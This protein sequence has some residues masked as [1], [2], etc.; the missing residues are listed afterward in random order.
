MK[1]GKNN[2]DNNSLPFLIAEV[3]QNHEG[4]LSLAHAYID[5]VA[6][7]GFD[8]IKFQTHIASAESTLNEKF[9]KPISNQFKSRYDYWKKMEFSESQWI[10]LSKHA[11][12]KNLVFLSS[13]FSMQAFNLLK[14]IG[15]KAW[16]ISSGEF[17]NPEIIDACVNTNKPILLSTGMSS[18][19]EIDNIVKKFKQ[20]KKDF[21]LFQTTSEYPLSLSR[22]GINIVDEFRKRYNCPVGLSDHSGTIFPSIVCFSL[23]INAIEVHVIFDK[24]MSGPDSQSS[25]TIEELKFLKLARDSIFSLRQNTIDKDKVSISLE[26]TKGLFSKSLALKKKV[27]KGNRILRNNLTLKKPG[28]GIPYEKINE[29]LNKVAKKDIPENL[30]LKKSDLNEN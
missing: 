18:L 8:A 25:I 14:K 16:K 10:E 11:E 5:A 30:L 21:L 28:T 6:S 23:M 4:S 9:R 1:I 17:F 7:T 3:G 22:V 12:E 26:K 15:M 13:P 29:V 20:K 19:K 24:N 27:F 2:I